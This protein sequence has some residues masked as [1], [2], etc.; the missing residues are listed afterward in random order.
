ML[1]S[2]LLDCGLLVDGGLANSGLLVGGSNLIDYRLAD[3]S[4]LLVEGT[5][6]LRVRRRSLLKC[7]LLRA[8]RDTG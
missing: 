3:S 2:W 5:R 1:G 4:S 8:T 6:L 7:G